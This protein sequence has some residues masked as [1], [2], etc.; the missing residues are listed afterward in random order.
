MPHHEHGAQ[1]PFT[2]TW[3]TQLKATHAI[4][5]THINSKCIKASMLQ[6]REHLYQLRSVPLLVNSSNHPYLETIKGRKLKSDLVGRDIG[7][8]HSKGGTVSDV[9]SKWGLLY[10]ANLPY[11][12]PDTGLSQSFRKISDS[13]FLCLHACDMASHH[14]SWLKISFQLVTLLAK[15]ER[16]SEV[17]NSWRTADI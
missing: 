16:M 13:L 6:L 10:Q 14:L 17:W 8:G 11:P 3:S 2:S 9:W 5:S 15:E 1:A 4:H 7:M 12:R